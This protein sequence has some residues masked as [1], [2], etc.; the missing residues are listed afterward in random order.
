MDYLVEAFN[1]ERKAN[2]KY[3][4]VL[5]QKMKSLEAAAPKWISVEERLPE[6]YNR[7][8][9][10]DVDG[11][12]M[13]GEIIRILDDRHRK[14]AYYCDNGYDSLSNVTH[15]MPLPEPPKEVEG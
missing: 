12:M 6:E 13:T 15:W 1:A 9:A 11:Y 14:T 4:A 2:N 7:V 10:V 5:L 3:I 8:L